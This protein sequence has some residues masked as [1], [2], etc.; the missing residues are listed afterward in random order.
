MAKVAMQIRTSFSVW[1][2]KFDAAY[3]KFTA[4]LE[5][6]IATMKVQD[7]TDEQIIARLERTL[8]DEVG[9]FGPF[10]GD[11]EK[12]ADDLSSIIAQTA[13]KSE[14][15]SE[16]KLEWVLDPAAK[17]HCDDCVANSAL[18]SQSFA[19]WEALGLPG[20]GNTECGEY[21]K[22]TLERAA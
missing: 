2:N 19:E 21:C 16:E 3:D 1:Q 12:Y 18:D 22:C 15:D 6:Q 5:G 10:V 13:S 17:E 11:I 4:D 8:T 14:F 20:V 9:V 7:M